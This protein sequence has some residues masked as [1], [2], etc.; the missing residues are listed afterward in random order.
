MADPIIQQLS[1]ELGQL[2]RSIRDMVD[3]SSRTA[4]AQRVNAET[5]LDQNLALE[6]YEKS[7]KAGRILNKQQDKLVKE[8][9]ALKKKEQQLQRD[10]NKARERALKDEKNK[11]LSDD[12]RQKSTDQAIAAMKRFNEAQAATQAKANEV[13]AS[14]GTVT[15][16][17]KLAG[18][19]LAWFGSALTAQGKQLLA[20]NKANSGVVEGTGGL[21]DALTTQQ[22]TALKLGMTG[23]E[24]AKISVA[25]RQMIN[26]MGG[27]TATLEQLNPS[28]ERMRI[29]TGSFTEALQL[30]METATDFAKK[31]VK[32]TQGA[33]EAYTNDLVQLQRQ[34]GMSSKA[35]ADYYNEISSEIDSIDTLRSA[36]ADER[37]AI[38]QS[39]RALVQQAI[40][41][42]M[43]A[44][45]AKEAAKMLNKMTAA[46]P[47]DRLKQAARIRAIGGAMGIAGADEA[48]KAVIAG[49]RATAEQKEAL[50]QFGT[51]AAN[52][53][54]QAAGQGLGS[55]I[56]ATQLADKLDLES[57]LGKGSPFST[58]LA[59]TLTPAVGDLTKAYVDGSKDANAQR[60][61]QLLLLAEQAKILAS[62]EH[63]W[64]TA[65]AGITALVTGLLG[66]KVVKGA[67]SKV[68]GAGQGL[69]G[70]LGGKTAATVGAE[71][72][73][74]GALGAAEAGQGAKAAGTS[75][76]V[77]SSLAKMAKILGPVASVAIGAYEG[78][79]EYDKTGKVGG[80]VGTGVGSAAGGLAGGWAGA[81]G[82]AALGA[83]LGSVVPIIGTAVGGILGGI[84]GAAGGGLLGSWGGGAAGKAIGGTFDTTGAEGDAQKKLQE[85]AKA[86]AES[87]DDIKDATKKS[88]TSLE[89]QVKK[90]DSSN[91]YLKQIV[92]LA[93]KQLDLSEKQLVAL[94]MTEKER[95]DAT[96]KTALRRDNKFSAQYNYV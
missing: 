31:G 49:K 14:L 86:S 74:A 91:D 50:A 94:T 76:K 33:M 30:S 37:E 80:A 24:F 9:I 79:E 70:K 23:E 60:A 21:L 73:E 83:A 84:A 19:A 5:L 85:F 47:L 10:Y 69:L 8:A 12:Q 35:A 82:G 87:N 17:S 67:A 93:E 46:K 62:G 39:Q 4:Q 90:L 75:A 68:I 43:S 56:F 11:K 18:A 95:T 78:K 96:N 1:A 55:E 2:T 52:A 22:T 40:A 58:S 16:G 34:T 81:A 88:A 41:A 92:M 54:D 36:R 42:G 38:L 72:A 3:A 64:G 29:L 71:T 57:F 13:G 32:P 66:G 77:A 65:A 25:N 45:Q 61:A 7:L 20:Q 15:K 59:T 28:I 51:A 6:E 48:A 27:S 53:M 63:Y 44:E 26:A 89:M